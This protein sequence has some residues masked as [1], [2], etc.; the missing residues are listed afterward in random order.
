MEPWRLLWLRGASQYRLLDDVPNYP[1]EVLSIVTP[2]ND[3]RQFHPHDNVGP[4]V[5]AHL[6]VVLLGLRHGITRSP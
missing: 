1:V 3:N 5:N 2:V 4:L 6:T